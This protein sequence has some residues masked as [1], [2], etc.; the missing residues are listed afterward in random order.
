MIADIESV[1]NGAD[2]LHYAYHSGLNQFETATWRNSQDAELNSGGYPCATFPLTITGK[3]ERK[4]GGST[5]GCFA[6]CCYRA[7][8]QFFHRTPIPQ[9]AAVFSAWGG[10]DYFWH[11]VLYPWRRDEHDPHGRTG[12]FRY[13]QKPQLAQNDCDRLYSRF[14]HYHIGAGFTGTGQPGAVGAQS[15]VDPF[16]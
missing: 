7:G 10:H 11:D 5:A 8:S 16:G 9:C 1:G 6:Y 14:H 3:A 4:T 12:W 13:N 2:T 15:G